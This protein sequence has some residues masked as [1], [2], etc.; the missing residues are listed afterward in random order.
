[1]DEEETL[2][3]LREVKRRTHDVAHGGVWFPVA[4]IAALMTLSIGLYAAPFGGPY[5]DDSEIVGVRP[6]VAYWAGLSAASR[7]PLLSYVYWLVATPLAF[8]S[9]C[10]I[11]PYF[12]YV[13]YCRN[14]CARP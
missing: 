1:M 8:V 7:S 6:D 12:F 3:H 11:E 9:V 14:L 13:R 2:R 4:V 10:Q 5:V